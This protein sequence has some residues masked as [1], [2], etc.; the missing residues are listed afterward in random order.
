MFRSHKRCEW[1]GSRTGKSPQNPNIGIVILKIY[2]ELILDNLSF[3]KLWKSKLTRKLTRR[4]LKTLDP[5][6]QQDT[7]TPVPAAPRTEQK[8]LEQGLPTSL[9]VLTAFLA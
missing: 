3:F 2:S 9:A 4:G 7:N 5:N 1:P 8:L 6:L